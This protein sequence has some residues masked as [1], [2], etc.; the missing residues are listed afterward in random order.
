[1]TSPESASFDSLL[2]ETRRELTSRV[3]A[4]QPALLKEIFDRS[5]QFLPPSATSRELVVCWLQV[6]P[7]EQKILQI[8]Y[9]CDRN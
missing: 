7:P 8:T 6:D 3:Q 1:M 4:E 2:D 5:I 9:M